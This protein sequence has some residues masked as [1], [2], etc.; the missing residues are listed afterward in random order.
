MNW[1][2]NN[3]LSAMEGCYDHYLVNFTKSKETDAS[4]YFIA[5]TADGDENMHN[6]YFYVKSQYNISSLAT[7]YNYDM[8]NGSGVLDLG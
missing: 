1:E 2:Y 4:S 6:P 8:R 3:Y 7:N 5:A